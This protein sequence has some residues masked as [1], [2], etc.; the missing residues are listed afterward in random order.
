MNPIRTF[1]PIVMA[2]SA[3]I[4]TPAIAQTRVVSYADLDLTSPAGQAAFENR[5]DNAIRQVCGSAWPLDLQSQHQMQRCRSQTRADIQAQ[6]N[7]ALAQAQNNRVR[8]SSR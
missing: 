6:R 8:L 1:V 3:A 2:L 7:D 4:S 5:I